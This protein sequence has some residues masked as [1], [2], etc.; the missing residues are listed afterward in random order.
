MTA[1]IGDQRV[2]PFFWISVQAPKVIRTQYSLAKSTKGDP[3]M[4]PLVAGDPSL[5]L[6]N[7]V[8]AALV[9]VANEDRARAAIDGTDSAGFDVERRKLVAYSG[10]SMSTVKKAVALLE[11]VGLVRV[12][13]RQV[14]DDDDKRRVARDLP[15]R[16]VLIESGGHQDDPAVQGKPQGGVQGEPE[17]PKKNSKSQEAKTGEDAEVEQRAERVFAYWLKLD[18]KKNPAEYKLTDKRRK[19]IVARL[20]DSTAEEIRDAL[21]GQ[22]HDPWCQETGKLDC[23][24][25]LRSREL[26]EDF[27]DRRRRQAGTA[28]AKVDVNAEQDRIAAAQG[29]K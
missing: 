10:A 15:N 20:G 8:Y 21:L 6:V 24:Y 29:I 2:Q 3:R 26:L 28:P 7:A 12:E 1:A 23:E 5:P 17:K 19:A 4:A 27:R 22:W 16:Y 18:P 9:E 14:R 13:R 25:S 11:R